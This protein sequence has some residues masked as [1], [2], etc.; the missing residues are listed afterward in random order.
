MLILLFCISC[1]EFCMAIE[2]AQLQSLISIGTFFTWA[3]NGANGFV[4]S[5]LD[6]AFCS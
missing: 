1:I 5:K 6:L 2:V 4:E 3:H